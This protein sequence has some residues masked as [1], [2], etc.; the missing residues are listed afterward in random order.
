MR[1]KEKSAFSGQRILAMDTG[2]ERYSR[3]L[4]LE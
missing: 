2:E 3:V 4:S 1:D